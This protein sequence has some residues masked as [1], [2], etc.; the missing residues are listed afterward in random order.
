MGKRAALLLMVAAMLPATVAEARGPLPVQPG[1][2]WKHN[3]TKIKL[4]GSSAGF[5]LREATDNTDSQSDVM[6]QYGND[7]GRSFATVY[8]FRAGLPDVSIWADRSELSMQANA[9]VYGK[10]DTAG[11]RWSRFTPYF[12]GDNS[13]IRLIYPV[14]GKSATSTGLIVAPYGNWLI[15][16]RITSAFFNAEQLDVKMMDFLAGLKLGKIKQEAGGAYAI[17]DCTDELPS[18]DA[19]LID[20]DKARPQAP[21]IGTTPMPNGRGFTYCRDKSLP[22]NMGVYRPVGSRD[23]YVITPADSGSALYIGPATPLPGA[24]G[25]AA[26]ATPVLLVTSDKAYG[27]QPFDGLPSPRQAFDVFNKTQPL[28][29]R[30]R[31]PGKDRDVVMGP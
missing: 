9:G 8:I 2:D 13:A 24:A 17:T 12:G 30:S 16:I 19:K 14:S 6:V 7:S 5:V 29:M 11:R 25:S 10:F 28:V 18:T 27:F 3:E 22:G 20:R 23:S 26:K 4:P 1:K 15:K 21:M 31:V